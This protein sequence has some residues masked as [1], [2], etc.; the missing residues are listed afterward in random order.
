MFG[1]LKEFLLDPY[2][3]RTF[4]QRMA[5]RFNLGSY[6]RRL[7][8]GAVDRPHYGHCIYNAAALA[9]KL[10][11]PRVTVIEFGVAGGNGLLNAEWHSR[12]VSK[13]LGIDIDIYGFDTGEGLPQ[14]LDYRDLPYHWKRGF[15]KMDVPNLRARLTSACLILGNIEETSLGFFKQYDPAP[16]GAIMH[17]FDFYSSTAV[18][19]KMLEAGDR[20]FLP[21]VFC[22]FDDTIG[23]EIE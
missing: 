19:L 11:L 9:K 22:Y 7:E 4:S 18:A 8:I 16:I 10:G 14:P 23:S 15:F 17:D 13:L 2:A 3:L 5:R 21:R 6:K 1:R 12:E 20:Y